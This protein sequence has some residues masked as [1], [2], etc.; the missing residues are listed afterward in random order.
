[1]ERDGF[2]P[3]RLVMAVRR[4]HTWSRLNP[5][6]SLQARALMLHELY[7]TYGF[8]E[9]E[10]SHPEVRIRFFR[11]TV[12]ANATGT[13]E[14]ELDALIHA[15]RETPLGLEALLRRMTILHRSAPLSEEQ[16]YF[17][18]R[19]TYSHLRP[20][21]KARLELLEEG[22]ETT[23]EL[24]E[25]THDSEGNRLTI[26]AAAN[27]KEVMRLHHLFEQAGLS[28]AFRPEHR[29]LVGVDQHGA[30]CGGL[31]YRPADRSTAHM[32]K[33]VV[34]PRY[35][36]KGVGDR[37]M[38]SF[39]ERMREEQKKKVT[40]GFFRPHYFYRFGFHLERGFAGL[41]RD[42]EQAGQV[43]RELPEGEE[44]TDRTDRRLNGAA[45]FGSSKSSRRS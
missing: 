44:P 7:E 16:L 41:V 30:V 18:A 5:G 38:E 11:M 22:G 42:L 24:V 1:V 31:F 10:E 37:I 34:G 3:R 14:T 15:H 23:A 6:A 19:M 35:R 9:L 12:F 27:P 39:M 4:Y 40:T 8:H 20:A 28:V 43:D 13:L 21:Q 45:P 36:R 2:P 29:F 33:I 17:L 25:E 32:E 26:R